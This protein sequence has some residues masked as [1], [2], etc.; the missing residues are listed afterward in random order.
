MTSEAKIAG[1]P[2][3]SSIASGRAGLVVHD[4]D[5]F[6]KPRFVCEH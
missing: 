5:A 3:R 2:G 1:N 4:L 6:G